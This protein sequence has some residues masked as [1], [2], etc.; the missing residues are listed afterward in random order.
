VVRGA[1]NGGTEGR[2]GRAD[3]GQ[4]NAACEQTHIAGDD[5]VTL[6]FPVWHI[7]TIVSVPATR[8]VG[9]RQ[10]WVSRAQHQCEWGATVVGVRGT[11][12]VALT[13]LLPVHTRNMSDGTALRCEPLLEN[14]T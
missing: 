9:V 10:R 8:K 12:V 11:R 1:P 7:Q 3:T 14:S 6:H 5:G 13:E 4:F 2:G